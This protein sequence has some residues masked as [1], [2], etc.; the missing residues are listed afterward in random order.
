MANYKSTIMEKQTGSM[1][2][3]LRP[4]ELGG[5]VRLVHGSI[6]P[7]EAYAAGS[8]LELARL[9]KGARLLPIS[10]IHFEAG[11]STGMTV[12]VGDS[13]DNDRYLAAK[14]P[15]ASAV[16]V[17]L[18]ANCL[19]DYVLEQEDVITATVAGAALTQGKMIVFDL[20]YVVD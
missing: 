1:A 4:S 9:P 10:Q 16:S 14:A 17:A 3:K 18:N 20:F 12:S 8:V 19:G 7:E 13:G 15:G 5:R 2:G 11:Q 6:V